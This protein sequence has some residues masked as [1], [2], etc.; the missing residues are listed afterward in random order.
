MFTVVAGVDCVVVVGVL[1]ALTDIDVVPN[2]LP[3]VG[4][5]GPGLESSCFGAANGCVPVEA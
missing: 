2:A 4:G 1:N 3:F 5:L